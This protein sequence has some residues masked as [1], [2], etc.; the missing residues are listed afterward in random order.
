MKDSG[1]IERNALT[2]NASWYP[3]YSSVC[4]TTNSVA[5]VALSQ[6]GSFLT[7][8]VFRKQSDFGSWHQC[9]WVSGQRLI[10]KDHEN[11]KQ[12]VNW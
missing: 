2:A 11:V 5:K 8:L 6:T 3:H 1:Y 4:L 9:V 12:R 10:W 7:Y